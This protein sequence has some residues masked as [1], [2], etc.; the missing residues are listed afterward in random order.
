MRLRK[1]D[2]IIVIAGRHKGQKGQIIKIDH[3]NQRVMLDTIKC[4]KHVKP[5]QDQ[6]QGEIKEIAKPIHVSNVAFID[7]KS[8][9]KP[10]RI[11]YKFDQKQKIRITRK[12]KTVI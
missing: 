12:S 3:K 11:G 4:I 9:D 5:K 6:K 8:K 1:G 10:T 7:K 2:S